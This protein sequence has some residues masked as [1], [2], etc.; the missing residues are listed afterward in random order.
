MEKVVEVI[1]VASGNPPVVP[2]TPKEAIIKMLD[3]L[4]AKE[5]EEMGYVREIVEFV[6]AVGMA[7]KDLHYRAKGDSFYGEH[8]LADLV[9]KIESLSDDLIEVYYLGEKG[10]EAPLMSDICRAAADKIMV[11]MAISD[12]TKPMPTEFWA[13]RLLEVCEKCAEHVE[14]VK[15]ILEPKAGT[16]AVLDEVSKEVLVAAGLLKRNL[17]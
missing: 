16:Q 17:K 4:E 14:K 3:E 1:P 12:S 6:K 15:A 10:A 9:W 8:L 13:S 5:R 11:S 2:I 7:A